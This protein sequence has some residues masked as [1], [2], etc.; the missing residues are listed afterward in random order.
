[1]EQSFFVENKGSIGNWWRKAY[2]LGLENDRVRSEN[3]QLTHALHG[4]VG[5]LNKT[6]A[7]LNKKDASIAELR[8]QLQF[9]QQGHNDIGAFP[10]TCDPLDLESLSSEGSAATSMYEDDGL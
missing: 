10:E 8:R 3:D 5:E 6:I 2:R 4:E 7:E 1:M 9:V